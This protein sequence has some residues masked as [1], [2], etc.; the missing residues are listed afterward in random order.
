MPGL[1]SGFIF[2]TP[3][4]VII[5]Q[6]QIGNTEGTTTNTD[7]SSEEI[8]QLKSQMQDMQLE[9]DLLKKRLFSNIL[10]WDCPAYFSLRCESIFI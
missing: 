3:I 6:K 7:I 9:I 4:I 10:D 2:M 8:K 1:L 5:T